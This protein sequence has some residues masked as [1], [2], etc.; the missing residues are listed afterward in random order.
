MRQESRKPIKLLMDFDE[1]CKNGEWPSST[2]VACYWC[3]HPFSSVPIGIPISYDDDLEK[4][5][6]YGC[7]C[8]CECAAAY[9]LNCKESA[10]E[11]M[12]RHCLINMLSKQMG[13][14]RP[15]RPAPSRLTLNIF[16]G[17]MNIDE[18]RRA[19][20]SSKMTLVNFPPMMTLTQQVEEINQSE[21]RSEY[22]YIPIDTDR[23]NKY[24]EKIK[25]KRNKPLA[26]FN[27]TLDY[28]MNLKFVS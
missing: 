22:R 8:S 11:I 27:N 19:C 14:S 7:F 17:P 20:T 2:S 18:F 23:V 5:K 9:N 3:V 13:F 10:D 6:V 24:K 1:K 4:F 28:T 21:M 15:V 25:L 12:S 26:N 16:G